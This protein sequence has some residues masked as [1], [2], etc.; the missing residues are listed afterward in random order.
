VLLVPVRQRLASLMQEQ[1]GAL[2]REVCDLLYGGA[3]R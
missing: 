3:M 2:A 1:A